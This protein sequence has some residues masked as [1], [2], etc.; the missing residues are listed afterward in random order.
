MIH[1]IS[2]ECLTYI[3]YIRMHVYNYIIAERLSTRQLI[4]LHI[5]FCIC[6]SV[7]L[8]NANFLYEAWLH[9]C[10]MIVVIT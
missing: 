3:L 4:P 1:N 9:Y 7:M 5:S 8:R 10:T 2:L 6:M